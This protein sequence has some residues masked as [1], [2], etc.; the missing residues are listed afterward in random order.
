LRYD[1]QERITAKEAQ[2]HPFFAVLKSK[3]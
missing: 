3:G 1:H 2:S